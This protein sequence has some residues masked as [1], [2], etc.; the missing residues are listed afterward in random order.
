M[1]KRYMKKI[2]IILVVILLIFVGA[3]AIFVLIFDINRYKDV[4]I[5][6]AS[7]TMQKDITLERISLD[8]T[9][10]LGCRIDG[11]ALKEKNTGW[12]S[13]WLKA[14][15]AEISVR[16]LPLFKKDVQ[17]NRI[18]IQRLDLKLSD[19]LLKQPMQSV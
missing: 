16:I 14:A 9:H 12:D 1:R 7:Q 4:I 8:F 10:G 13:A 15:S 5:E 3:I 2:F 11:L 18:E 17:V 19:E 6:K